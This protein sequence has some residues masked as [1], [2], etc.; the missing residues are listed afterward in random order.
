MMRGEV[1]DAQVAAFA[2]AVWFRGLSPRETVAFTQALLDSGRTLTWPEGGAPVADKHSTG[3]VGD[4]VSLCLAPW[5]AA[6]GVRVP[7]V[8]GRGLGHTGGTLDKLS[9]IPG[10][11]SDLSVAELRAIVERHGFALAG[12][13]DDMCPADRHLYAL[14][15]VT[16]TVDSIP[17]ITASIIS[18]K[19]A[20]GLDVLV[21]DV[22]VGSGAF[23]KRFSDAEEL[24]DSLVATGRALG[25]ETVAM[26]TDMDQP[27]GRAVGNRS[28]LLEALDVLVGEGP[29]DLEELTIRLGVQMLTGAGLATSDDDARQQLHDARENGAALEALERVV[30]AQG[31]D[32][33]AARAAPPPPVRRDLIARRAGFVARIDTEAVGRAAMNLGAGRARPGDRIDVD[34]GLTLARKRA[35]WVEAGDVLARIDGRSDAD[36]DGAEAVVLAAFEFADEPPA[37]VPLV[38]GRRP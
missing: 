25:T 14:R 32:L 35:D 13:S 3:G 2:M 28:E 23:M 30:T 4:K 24:A 31:G 36:V 5:V 22:K 11:R 6:C 10:F 27:L 33:A 17:L 34:V 38:L 20:E 19:V 8:S 1:T 12:Q 21:L 7:M 37:A 26:L 16:A 29:G 15:D 18:K 9:A